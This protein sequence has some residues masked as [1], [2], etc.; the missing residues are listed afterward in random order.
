MSAMRPRVA[1]VADAMCGTTSRFGASSSGWSPGSGSGS[2]TSSAAPAISP[3][4]RARASA[5]VSTIGAARRV[6]QVGS[7]L[8]ARERLVADQAARLRCERAVEGHE[9]GALEQLLERHPAAAARGE[10]L[11]A[12]ALERGG[13]QPARS[14]RSRRCRRLP[15][16]GPDPASA[17][18][19]RWPTRPLRTNAS[20]SAS[21]RAMPS[22]SASAR[23]AV[24][25]V[26]TPGV[27]PT[28][29]PRAVAARTSTLST[30]T[31]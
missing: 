16:A 8:H 12:E 1:C 31:A 29:M 6:H 18:A 25:S 22:I 27:L 15:R 19:P 9:V 11:A 14:G 26:S 4:P 21:R 28:G 20:P 24:D 17:Q 2:V 5:S 3:A 23:S 30:P 13:R 10:E 7:G